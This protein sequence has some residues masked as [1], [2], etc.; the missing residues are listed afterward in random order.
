[1]NL[2]GGKVN[3]MVSYNR[4]DIGPPQGQCIS[5]KMIKMETGGPLRAQI[6]EFDRPGV[7]RFFGAK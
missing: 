3:T 6:R 4:F 5:Q 1:M 7:Q 2:E